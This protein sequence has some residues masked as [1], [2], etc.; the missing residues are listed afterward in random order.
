MQTIKPMQDQQEIFFSNNKEDIKK[1]SSL[2][3]VNLLVED[4]KVYVKLISPQFF[5]LFANQKI[6]KGEKI[7]DYAGEICSE[8][9][10]NSICREN[11]QIADEIS[12]YLVEASVDDKLVRA[13]PYIKKSCNFSR[14]ANHSASGPNAAILANKSG[15]LPCLRALHTIPPHWQILLNYGKDYK[16]NSPVITLYPA[17]VNYG[18]N[19]PCA[20]TTIKNLTEEER[21]I[22]EMK[23]TKNASHVNIKVPKFLR[24][25]TIKLDYISTYLPVFQITRYDPLTLD[26]S[27]KI[28]PLMWACFQGKIAKIKLLLRSG[29]DVNS[30]S[31]DGK[32][33]LIFL[34]LGKGNPQKCYD[35]IKEFD[36]RKVIFDHIYKN[37]NLIIIAILA[38][39]QNNEKIFYVEKLTKN[40]YFNII[41]ESECYINLVWFCLLNK[42]LPSLAVILKSLPPAI[43]KNF[44]V[45]ETLRKSLLQQC[46]DDPSQA[47]VPTVKC[48]FRKYGYKEKAMADFSQPPLKLLSLTADFPVK[49]VKRKS[50]GSSLTLP[51][52][53]K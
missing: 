32:N 34:I 15:V 6:L 25:K 49:T 12:C 24:Q 50:S 42:Y 52:T 30:L 8:K 22:F 39:Q 46:L 16:F 10:L 13:D 43:I 48:L 35:V 1:L 37:Y 45:D 20:Y 41:N 4:S 9:Q 31:R 2:T 7:I 21:V 36:D 44:L 26:N 40:Y 38:A 23:A 19:L 33:A 51:P 53:K 47:C 3:K 17:P 29:A 18:F 28:T 5:G 27:A 14:F 11:P